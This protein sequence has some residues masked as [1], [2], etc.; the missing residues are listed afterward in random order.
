MMRLLLKVNPHGAD[1]C[2][3]L[4]DL[5]FLAEPMIGTLKHLGIRENLPPD[6]IS[7]RK[8]GFARLTQLKKIVDD[9]T[10]ICAFM[11]CSLDRQAEMIKAV[12]GWDTGPLELIRISERIINV[13]RLFN[14]R[15]GFS[16]DDDI[17]PGRFFKPK[18]NGILA[19]RA[20][21]QAKIEEAKKYYYT[22]MGWNEEGV[23]LPE[24]VEELA[25]E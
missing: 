19:K 25:I 2:S 5:L 15:E 12:T 1:H 22:L 10:A 24:K 17:L 3:S 18:T 14:L 8:V 16:S 21:D 6:E 7:P 9:C 4:F 11:E 23:P 20:V 13:M